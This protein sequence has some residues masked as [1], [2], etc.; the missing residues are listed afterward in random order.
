MHTPQVRRVC[1]KNMSIAIAAMLMMDS[2]IADT[3]QAVRACP[4]SPTHAYGH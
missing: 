1:N 3:C 2:D 4:M